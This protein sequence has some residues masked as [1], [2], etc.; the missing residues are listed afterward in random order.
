MSVILVTGADG[1][2]GRHLMSRLASDFPKARLEA[3]GFDLCDHAA[4]NQAVRAVQPSACV[5]LAAVSA[6]SAAR[7]NPAQAWAVNLAGTLALARALLE[8]APTCL[9]LHVS[10]ADAYGK[11]F[12]NG[13]IVDES[14]ALAPLNVYAATKAAAD[15]ALGAMA[16]DG[17]RVLRVRPFNHTG[18][19]QSDAF[20]IAA[21][22]RQLAMIE[23]GR[24]A[25]VLR[26]G[27]LDSR[28]DFLDVR[29]VVAAYSLCLDRPALFDTG[30]ILNIASG[31]SHRIGDILQIML[32]LTGLE[33]RVETEET[34]LRTTDIPLVA[35][36]SSRL[37]ALLGWRQTIDLRQ[38]LSDVLNDWRARGKHETLTH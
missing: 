3:A 30:L 9:L 31:V 29:D 26:V 35:A 5:H 4:I 37:A 10:S 38:T 12:N 6:I 25:P 28:R 11:S 24:Q 34:R 22:A 36:D 16:A 32:D 20:V 23:T 33:P 14:T 13:K 2:V 19:G 27:A 8:H 1:F 18:P 7:E 17:L 15:L 21:F